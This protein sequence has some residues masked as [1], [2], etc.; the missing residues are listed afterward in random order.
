[1]TAHR[2]TADNLPHSIV[3]L[4]DAPGGTSLRGVA[5]ILNMYDMILALASADP[6]ADRAQLDP[7]EVAGMLAGAEERLGEPTGRDDTPEIARRLIEEC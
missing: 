3:A 2:W 4:H 1:M 6:E 5:A 7:A